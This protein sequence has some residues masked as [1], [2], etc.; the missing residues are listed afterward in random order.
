[1]SKN[2]DIADAFG[3]CF[4][5]PI[6]PVSVRRVNGVPRHDCWM[7]AAYDKD[8]GWG[9]T[10]HAFSNRLHAFVEV[11]SDQAEAVGKLM[12]KWLAETKGD[13]PQA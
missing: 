3:K 9:I 11:Q 13:G 7:C 10:M 4:D 8:S 1:M 6:T 2:R 5:P 12:A